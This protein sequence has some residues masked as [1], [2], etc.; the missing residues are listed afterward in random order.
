MIDDYTMWMT[1]THKQYTLT[2]MVH[3][4]KIHNHNL[5]QQRYNDH[6]IG[7]TI[8]RSHSTKSCK[9]NLIIYKADKLFEKRTGVIN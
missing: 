5:G 1:H 4:M 2:I 7:G 9:I 3:A 8:S 6:S